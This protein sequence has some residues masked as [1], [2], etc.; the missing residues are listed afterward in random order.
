MVFSDGAF[1][2]YL[3]VESYISL[4]EEV[5]KDSREG[6]TFLLRQNFFLVGVF[7]S[8]THT[9][10]HT[11]TQTHSLSV[12]LPLTHTHT[13]TYGMASINNSQET[14]F[15]IFAE[16]SET[17]EK[18]N[19]ILDKGDLLMTSQVLTQTLRRWFKQKIP[20]QLNGSYKAKTNNKFWIRQTQKLQKYVTPDISLLF[21]SNFVLKFRISFQF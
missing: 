6:K 14:G 18:S 11:H 9:H 12:S 4:S 7:Y 3:N 20:H 2:L 10:T 5:E 1:F 19:L 17:K 21:E 8:H 13:H 15:R 16:L